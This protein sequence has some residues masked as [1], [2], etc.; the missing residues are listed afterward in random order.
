MKCCL[1]IP[2]N[3]NKFGSFFFPF[4]FTPPTPTGGEF[5]VISVIQKTKALTSVCVKELALRVCVCVC[6]FPFPKA[7]PI[8]LV[9]LHRWAGWRCLVAL[10]AGNSPIIQVQDGD[11]RWIALLYVF[12]AVC[13]IY[14]KVCVGET[15]CVVVSVSVSG[16]V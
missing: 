5:R 14:V 12:I 3:A 15:H 13:V 4:L 10:F 7:P 9:A 11:V 1:L 8:C 6:V 16:C 2:T